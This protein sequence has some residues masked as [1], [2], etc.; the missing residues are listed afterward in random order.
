MNKTVVFS[1]L[2]TVIL[3]PTITFILHNSL[4]VS[5]AS[6]A[7]SNVIAEAIQ[8]VFNA[9]AHITASVFAALVRKAA[10]VTE[11]AVLGCEL[12]GLTLIWVT[13]KKLRA[14]NFI[15]TPLFFSLLVAVTDE[16]IQTFTGR[17]STVKDVLI[18]FIGSIAGIIIVSLIFAV[19]KSAKRKRT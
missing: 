3:I 4:T 14:I 2:L 17:T 10:H 18:D 16:Y 13:V 15:C 1:V 12:M 11:F 8:P 7:Q 19:V 6:Y 5:E 9:D